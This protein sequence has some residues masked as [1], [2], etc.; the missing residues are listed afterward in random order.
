[1]QI[2]GRLPVTQLVEVTQPCSSCLVWFFFSGRDPTN[3]ILFSERDLGRGYT[4]VDGA[5]D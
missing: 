1:M 3:I 2:L 5:V 4:Y